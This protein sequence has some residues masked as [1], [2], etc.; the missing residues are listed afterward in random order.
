MVD[1]KLEV[2]TDIKQ[3]EKVWKTVSTNK[4]ISEMW[5]FKLCFHKSFDHSPYFIVQKKGDEIVGLLPLSFDKIKN[6]FRFF[7]G[8]EEWIEK[9]PI[10][11]KN[12][13]TLKKLIASVPQNTILTC[14][15]ENPIYNRY[16]NEEYCTY[17]LMPPK[18]DYD[19][20]NYFKLFNKKHLKNIMRDIK[21]LEEQKIEVSME[22]RNKRLYKKMI[23]WNLKAF[24]EKSYFYDG[25]FNKAFWELFDFFKKKDILYMV[26]IKIDGELAAVDF[27]CVYNNVLT[28]LV[29]GVNPRYRDLG[30]AKFI[31]FEHIKY[32]FNNKLDRIEFLGFDFNW[33]EHWHLMKEKMFKFCNSK[34]LE[35]M[36]QKHSDQYL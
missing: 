34:R 6:C 9:N 5:E 30:V 3:C 36:M 4:K 7:P 23:E 8:D 28:V 14:I 26:S 22:T 17:S 10:F 27:G 35:K 11:F 2:V 15:E 31:N 1:Y 12:R 18:M 32:G 29:G 25:K 19:I 16:F 33:K 20:N 13:N 21:R 24:G